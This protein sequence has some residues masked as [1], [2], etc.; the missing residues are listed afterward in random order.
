MYGKRFY[1][2]EFGIETRGAWLPDTFGFTPA[3]PQILRRAG[4]EWFF[5]QKLSWNQYNELPHHTFL[6][7]GIDGSRVFTHF[8]PS[9]TYGGNATAAEL[10]GS[11]RRFKDH[12]LA[13]RSLYPFGHGDG[14]GGPTAE[15]LEALRRL[16]VLDGL[17][18]LELEGPQAFFA[19]AAAERADWPVWVG[20]LYLELHRGTYTTHADVKHANRRGEVALHDAELW[21]TVAHTGRADYPGADLETAWKTL[22]VQ[23]FHDII[24]GSGIHW[25]YDD[26]R[27]DHADVLET[28]ERV[29]RDALPHLTVGIDTGGRDRPV[30]VFNSASH[31]RVGLVAL[32]VQPADATALVAEGTDGDRSPLHV[33]SDRSVLAHVRVPACGYAVYDLTGGEPPAPPQ[34]PVDTRHLQNQSLRA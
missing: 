32:D 2:D 11:V 34:L 25:V 9:N 8:P 21:A 33:T 20:E 26:A 29:T 28:A 22:L 30:V 12:D 31:D 23:Q 27:R 4:V 24:P 5:T 14:G 3:L 10:L 18:H 13:T 1:L 7:E 6:W 15:M 17:P 16:R 19:A